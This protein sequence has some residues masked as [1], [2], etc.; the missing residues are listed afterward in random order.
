MH[1]ISSIFTIESCLS[2]PPHPPD[3]VPAPAAHLTIPG[4]VHH[5]IS[6]STPVP[7]QHRSLHPPEPG[8][9]E[10]A[11]VEHHVSDD[12]LHLRGQAVKLPGVK[13]PGIPQGIGRVPVEVGHQVL[14][15]DPGPYG[16][17]CQ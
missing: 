16:L 14:M 5:L 8:E 9:P 1:Y 15:R 12:E 2:E 3:Q 6:C 13:P 17:T 11:Q 7:P 10:V 4:R